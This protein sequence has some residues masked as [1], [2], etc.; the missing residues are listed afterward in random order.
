MKKEQNKK[1]IVFGRP[2]FDQEELKA[3]KEV[4]DSGW[5]GMGPKC[6]EF[7]NS[8]AKYVGAKYAVSVSSCTAA[9]HLSLLAAGVGPGDEVITTPL[10]FVATI[11]AIEYIGATPVL[12]DVEPTSLNINTDLIERAITKKTKAIIPVHFGGLPCD[13]EK[14]FSIAKKYN[15]TV[16]EDAAHA[17][18]SK[19]R[20]KMIGG[21]DNSIACFSF[22]PNK[23]LTSVEGGMITTDNKK[24]ADIIK[25]TR[26]HGTDSEAWKRYS[27]GKKMVHSEMVM[28]GFKYNLTDLQAAIGITQLKK[29]DGFQKT[30]EKYVKIYDEAL[31]GYVDLQ[32]RIT[33]FGQHAFHL[34][35]ILLRLDEL[36]ATRDD[37]IQQIRNRGIGATV[38]YLPVHM[39]RYYRNK[40]N[41][42]KGSFPIAEKTYERIVTLPLTPG[43]TDEEVRRVVD[44]VREVIIAN[45]KKS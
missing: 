6:E 31:S 33:H 44:T 5:V 43:M 1:F 40:F 20:G 13:M 30:R 19:W 22:Y 23:N 8:F 2:V 11:N 41:F 38:H 39:H 28:Q 34:Y 17:I 37:I 15:L 29:F 42:K 14:I 3:V 45:S 18:G 16:I 21:L 25:I 9:L 7:E 27:G 32:K 24:V 12:V 26:L 10:T 36:S 4:L 35:L